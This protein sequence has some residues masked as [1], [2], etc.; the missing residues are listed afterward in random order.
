M[1]W[2]PF[3]KLFKNLTLSSFSVSCLSEP[4]LGDGD[5]PLSAS[6]LATTPAPEAPGPLEVALD[7]T[8]GV[9]SKDMG[10]A[11]LKN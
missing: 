2:L 11:D 7:L 5:A 9:P 6:L 8:P 3:Q 1:A 10:E 4:A